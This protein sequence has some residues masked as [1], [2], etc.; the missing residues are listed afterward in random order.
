MNNNEYTLLDKM[1]MTLIFAST[2]FAL[3][4][5][6]Y[7]VFVFDG[8]LMIFSEL[9]PFQQKLFYGIFVNLFIMAVSFIIAI[10]NEKNEDSS[11]KN[12]VFVRKEEYKALQEHSLEQEYE[13]M[14]QDVEINT[15]KV[16]LLSIKL[17]LKILKKI[18]KHKRDN[19][20]F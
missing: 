5:E 3:G 15:L 4:T 6:L 11:F 9:K 19:K 18:F 13:S 12:Y 14:K 16:R 20:N 1:L 10:I 7:F 8:K 2:L 17:R